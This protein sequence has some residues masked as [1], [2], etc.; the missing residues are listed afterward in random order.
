MIEWSEATSGGEGGGLTPPASLHPL[1]PPLRGGM[2]VKPFPI[3]NAVAELQRKRSFYFIKGAP[4]G[5][6]RPANA[7][8]IFDCIR[9]F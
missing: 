1:I 5:A 3:G 6:R 2:G 7:S 9:S 8:T 4:R